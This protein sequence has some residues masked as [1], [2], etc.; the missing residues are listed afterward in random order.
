MQRS[1]IAFLAVLMP[2][3]AFAA[4]SAGGWKVEQRIA[5]GGEGGW[6][7]L[8]LDQAAQHLYVSHSDRVIV[9]DAKDGKRVGEIDGLSGV[10][11]I[12]IADDLHRG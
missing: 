4:T 7:Y 3:C 5:I 10:H 2:V 9:L 11:G 12:A 6:D 1:M 8:A